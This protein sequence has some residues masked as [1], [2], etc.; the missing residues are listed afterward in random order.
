MNSAPHTENPQSSSPWWWYVSVGIAILVG[1]LGSLGLIWLLSGTLALVVLGITIAT[2]LESV[3]GWLEHWIPRVA[4]IFLLYIAVLIL[5]TGIGWI[6]IPVL[7]G[8]IREVSGQIPEL[9]KGVEPGL[10]NLGD[11]MSVNLLD[12]I[13]SRLG[14]I[15][16]ALVSLPVSILSSLLDIVLIIFISIYSLI[17]KDLLIRGFLSFLP[18]DRHPRAREV[19]H[20]MGREIGGYL[21]GAVLDGVI[22]GMTTYVGLLIIGVKFALV[23]S[24]LAGLLEVIPIIGP[25]IAAIPMVGIALTQSGGKAL[26]ALIFVVIIHQFE[27]NIVFPNVM[28]TQTAISPLIVLVAFVA[29]GS[30][31]GVLGAL[32]AIPVVAGVR[33]LL[34]QLVAPRL[35]N[36]TEAPEAGE[37]ESEASAES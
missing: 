16:S 36:R 23:L 28:R 29:G 30:L 31:G 18:G 2:T 26:L 7:V 1:G 32:T 21:R 19:L 15:E 33:V 9:I 6:I 34:V 11:M 20:E 17:E 24:L 8:Q 5:L 14:Q 37:G 13:T 22:I 4:A 27:G 10:R 35:A 12:M 25:I 3:V